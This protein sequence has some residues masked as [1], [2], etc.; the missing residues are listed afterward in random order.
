M[1]NIEQ[2]I[3]HNRPFLDT[4]QPNDLRIWEAIEQRL[5]PAE[6]PVMELVKPKKKRIIAFLPSWRQAAA[7][8]VVLSM[9]VAMGL[10]W[11][12]SDTLP[13]GEVG[14]DVV[15][16]NISPELEQADKFYGLKVSQKIE[17]LEAANPDPEVMSDLKQLDEVQAE[18]RKELTNAP[19]GSQDEIVRTMIRNYQIKLDILEKVLNRIEEKK[20]TSPDT[21]LLKNQNSSNNEI[22]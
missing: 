12:K 17:A 2:F 11:K 16:T 6:T 8:L 4:E 19:K 20:E 21:L 18:L 1:D 15:E 3:A 9:G 22:I 5:P 10:M 13:M 7:A 14:S